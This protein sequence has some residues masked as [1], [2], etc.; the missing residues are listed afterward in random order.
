VANKNTQRRVQAARDAFGRVKMV[1]RKRRDGV[2]IYPA[3]ADLELAKSVGRKTRL[4]CKP[5]VGASGP[6]IAKRLGHH[7][8]PEHQGPR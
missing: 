8:N 2:N 6:A 1:E 3:P 5:G 7:L 4:T